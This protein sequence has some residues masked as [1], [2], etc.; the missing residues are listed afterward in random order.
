M[1]NE[2][3]YWIEEVSYRGH[4]NFNSVSLFKISLLKIWFRNICLPIERWVDGEFPPTA[5]LGWSTF[6]PSLWFVTFLDGF[7]SVTG[8]TP[9]C[10]TG[11]LDD[12]V[13]VDGSIWFTDCSWNVWMPKWK[14]VFIH[15]NIQLSYILTQ[16]IYCVVK[17]ISWISFYVFVTDLHS[18][19]SYI[20]G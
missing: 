2:I 9:M 5:V 20:Y 10:K 1:C 19:N 3:Y 13:V 18:F 4:Q 7:A 14:I 15:K 17:D 6:V 8:N 11:L 12:K 16:H